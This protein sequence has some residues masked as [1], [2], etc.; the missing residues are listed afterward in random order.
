MHVSLKGDSHL[1]GIESYVSGDL[2]ANDLSLFL[3]Q[4]DVSIQEE[5]ISFGA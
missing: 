4:I 1:D 2:N 3:H 5:K